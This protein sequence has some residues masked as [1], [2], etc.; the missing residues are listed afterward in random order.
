MFRLHGGPRARISP[1]GDPRA[2]LNES[3]QPLKARQGQ[4][5]ADAQKAEGAI[6]SCC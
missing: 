5:V 2:D 4:F 6:L 1:L 3:S